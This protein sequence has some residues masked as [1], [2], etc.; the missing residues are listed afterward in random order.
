MNLDSNCSLTSI[1]LF[2]SYIMAR[3]RYLRWDDNDIDKPTRLVGFL[4]C[5]FN[6]TT[7]RGWICLSNRTHYSLY[8]G[9]TSLRCCSL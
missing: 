6:E 2:F 1:Q 3:T 8:I 7:V 9:P 5:Y 4:Q